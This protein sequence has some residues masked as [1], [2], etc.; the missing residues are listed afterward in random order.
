MTCPLPTE[1]KT[2]RLVQVRIG[3]GA[4]GSDI[5]FLRRSDG[6][7][8]TLENERLERFDGMLPIGP[9]TESSEYTINGALPET[10]FLIT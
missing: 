6:G 2:G 5:Y 9:D 10:G 3:R 4:F 1:E 8:V 7:L